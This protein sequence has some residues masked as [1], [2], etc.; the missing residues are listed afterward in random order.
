[1]KK[2]LKTLKWIESIPTKKVKINY[3][4][5]EKVIKIFEFE[6]DLIENIGCWIKK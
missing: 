2:I 4:F 5:V 3:N 1:M 6:S